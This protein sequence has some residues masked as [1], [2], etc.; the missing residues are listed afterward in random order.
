MQQKCELDVAV[1]RKFI[2]KP[3]TL[4]E[5]SRAVYVFHFDKTSCNI[6]RLSKKPVM[7][8]GIV[9]M[10]NRIQLSVSMP[11]QIRIR[12]LPSIHMLE[13]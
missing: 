9:L 8:I 2:N 5:P 6:G 10:R 13:N 4:L 12:T 1:H 7:W 11:T 3:V